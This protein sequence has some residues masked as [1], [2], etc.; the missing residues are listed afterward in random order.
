MI[1]RELIEGIAAPRDAA[2]APTGSSVKIQPTNRTNQSPKYKN[3]AGRRPAFTTD[4]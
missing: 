1:E 2:T 4:N 3:K